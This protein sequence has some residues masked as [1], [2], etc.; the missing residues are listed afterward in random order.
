MKILFVE[1]HAVFAGQVINQ[2]LSR[3][4]VS[5]VPSLAEARR[6]LANHCFDLLLVDYDLE[7]G[8]GD[9]LVRE[10][11]AS[12]RTVPTIGVSSH[13][14]GNMALKAAGAG[15]IC[16]KMQFDRIQ[17]VIDSVTRAT[18]ES[19]SGLVWWVIPGALA[20][21]PMPYIHP[22]RRLNM[23]GALSDYDDELPVLYNAGIRAA[24]S[25][26]NIPSDAAVYQSAGFA[27]K[28]L[29]VPDGGA[30]STEQAQ[31][32]IAF[33][34]TQL[35]NQCPVAV[36]CEAGLG[37]TGTMLAAYLISKGDDAGTAIGRVRSAER[38]AVETLRQIQF[39]EQVAAQ[40][41]R[42]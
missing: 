17:S 42:E 33:A 26:L 1:N 39:L 5:V 35:A 18:P 14:E 28:C 4:T 8:K 36:H 15:A 30:P 27:F 19:Q 31:E 37:R 32:F 40:R 16:S 13:D 25:L 22:D 24:V 41:F 10:V 23:G 12:G 29:P 3:H 2:F 21:M 7:D 11:H 9:S 6:A 20:G 34:D 38:S